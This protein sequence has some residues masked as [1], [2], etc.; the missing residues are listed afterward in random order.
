MFQLVYIA[1]YRK[2][3][4]PYWL[5]LL[6]NCSVYNPNPSKAFGGW[7]EVA[8][9]CRSGFIVKGLLEL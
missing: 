2:S 9:G 1:G 7:L 4:A 8:R 5:Y 3:K 6:S